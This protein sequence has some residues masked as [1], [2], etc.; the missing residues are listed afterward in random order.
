M[1]SS[2]LSEFVILGGSAAKH[3]LRQ[4]ADAAFSAAEAEAERM[5]DVRER[6]F[7]LLS[8]AEE[9]WKAGHL[10]EARRDLE[11]LK[12]R[13]ESESGLADRAGLLSLVNLRLYQVAVGIRPE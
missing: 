9:R 8:V 1:C 6:L 10:V 4:V 5:A 3:G 11:A 2:D 13:A 7:M 12:A